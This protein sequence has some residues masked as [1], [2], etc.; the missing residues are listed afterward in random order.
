MKKINI[1]TS[2][3]ALLIIWISPLSFIL[4]LWVMN[5][6]LSIIERSILVLI[7]FFP[8]YHLSKKIVLSKISS[9]TYNLI[10]L[11]IIWFSTMA[12]MIIL[13]IFN[14]PLGDIPLIYAFPL[15]YLSKRLV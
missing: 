7:Y 9:P 2:L 13:I 15:Y 1:N 11:A 5:I 10:F 6:D 3:I 12:T 4:S 14:I 8:I